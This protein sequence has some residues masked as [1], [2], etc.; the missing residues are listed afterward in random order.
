MFWKH[1]Y[2]RLTRKL[3]KQFDGI[4]MFYVVYRPDKE[5]PNV[6]HHHI[7]PDL[8]ED[9]DLMEALEFASIRIRTFYENHL[10]LLEE[11]T[12]MRGL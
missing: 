2:K 3:F 9:K 11:A 7:H 5:I 4:L 1:L 10:D 8:K 12:G 6:F